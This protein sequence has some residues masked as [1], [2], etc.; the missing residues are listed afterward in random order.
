[1]LQTSDDFGVDRQQSAEIIRLLQKS[2]KNNPGLSRM[3]T[4]GDRSAQLSRFESFSRVLDGI[5][6]DFAR[7]SVDAH[8]LDLLI[9]LA[10]SAGQRRRALQRDIPLGGAAMATIVGSFGLVKKFFHSRIA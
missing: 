8:S 2:N 7:T 1:M 10:T 3:M 4:K 6:L 5:L 9:A